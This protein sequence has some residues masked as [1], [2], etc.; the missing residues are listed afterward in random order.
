M[1][2]N[3]FPGNVKGFLKQLFYTE[4]ENTNTDREKVIEIDKNGNKDITNKAGSGPDVENRINDDYQ[5][6]AVKKDFK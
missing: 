1:K 4:S 6:E 3:P 5:S 2:E